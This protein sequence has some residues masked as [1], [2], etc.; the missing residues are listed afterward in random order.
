MLIYW[1]VTKKKSACSSTRVEYQALFDTTTNIIWL[2]YLLHEFDIPIL[3]PTLLYCDDLFVI[4]L[5]TNPNFHARMKHV[6][7]KFHF[8]QDYIQHHI[9][10]LNHISLQDQLDDIFT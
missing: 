10:F 5:A 1:K 8:I 9:I 7:I 2:C 3:T 4:V 6:E